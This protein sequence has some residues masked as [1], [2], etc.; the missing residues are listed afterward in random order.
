MKNTNDKVNEA[1]EYAINNSGIEN[2][3]PTKEELAKI[4]TRL[5]EKTQKEK[6]KTNNGSTK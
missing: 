6:G 3:Q 5:I 1:I 2:M 4:K